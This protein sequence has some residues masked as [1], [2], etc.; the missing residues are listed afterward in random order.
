MK[1]YHADGLRMDGL[2]SSM[3]RLDYGR[4]TENGYRIF[5]VLMKNLDGIEFLKHLNSVFRRIFRKGILYNGR[6][7]RLAG[8]DRGAG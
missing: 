5:T 6:G 1:E 7:C 4:K 8:Y 2:G 3:L